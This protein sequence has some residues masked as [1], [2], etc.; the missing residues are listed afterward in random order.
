MKEVGEDVANRREEEF[1]TELSTCETLN[2]RRNARGE[3]PYDINYFECPKHG[4]IRGTVC[5]YCHDETP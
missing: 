2:E 5:P 4:T 1:E 3:L